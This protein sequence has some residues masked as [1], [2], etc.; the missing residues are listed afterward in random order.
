MIPSSKRLRK[1]VTTQPRTTSAFFGLAR[2]RTLATNNRAH[3]VLLH[4]MLA[5]QDCDRTCA[6]PDNQAVPSPSRVTLLKCSACSNS[7]PKT[8]FTPSQVKKK[9]ER[10]CKVCVDGQDEPKEP[11][12]HQAEPPMELQTASGAVKSMPALGSAVAANPIDE[13]AALNDSTDAVAFHALKALPPD[14]GA[15]S[16]DDSHDP[17]AS[18]VQVPQPHEPP[19]P[20]PPAER[21]PP[22]PYERTADDAR[23]QLPEYPASTARAPSDSGSEASFS[24]SDSESYTGTPC[25]APL[26]L[27]SILTLTE[28]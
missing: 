25:T 1:E 22:P 6:K 8:T 15:I 13:S 27:S 7:L 28:T 23:G 3:V 9:D 4:L 20:P 24:D 10:R 5:D 17:G 18:G 11:T 12:L 14:A 21:P 16:S 2:Q 19:P 26:T